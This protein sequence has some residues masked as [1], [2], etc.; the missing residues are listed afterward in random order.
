[1]LSL[2][3]HL[4][5]PGGPSG[6]LSIL[7]LHR[8]EA[9]PDPL[10]PETMDAARFDALCGWLRS[11]FN[12]VPLTEAVAR[13]QSGTLPARAL[14]IT[15]DDGYADNHDLALPI[16]QRHGLTATFFIA[17]GFL[18]GG[19]MWND[20]IIESFRTTP[21]TKLDLRDLLGAE[22]A[23]YRLENTMARRAALDD[24]IG[25][26]KYLP[27]PQ[28][29]ALVG[30]IAERARARLPDDLMLTSTQLVAL[31]RAGMQ[32]GA[33][34]MTHPI[35]ATLDRQAASAEIAGSKRFLENLL[36]EPITLFAYP[37]GKPGEDYHAESVAAVRSAGFDAA[38]STTRGAADR[39]TD[40]FQLP[41]FM[42]WDRT[43]ARFGVR[44]ISNL[45]TSRIRQVGSPE[46][47]S[48]AP[49]HAAS[50]REL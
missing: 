5:A 33:H 32:I 34:T 31:R 24:V 4:L 11:L 17:T 2:L 16:L 25:R 38:V 1:M 40:P 21:S 3:L 8:V 27:V 39:S 6:R 41:R 22:S 18:D 12:V 7:D 48:R 36:G 44:M 50:P 23:V 19:R 35:L 47:V 20:T 42:P 45:W 26:V 46:T 49:A 15:F 14:A 43:R 29:L 37:N 30:R 28:R 10:F 13:L 9:A